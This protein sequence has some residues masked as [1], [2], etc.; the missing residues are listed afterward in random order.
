MTSPRCS[1]RSTTSAGAPGAAPIE[2][3]GG[4]RS[5]R[6]ASTSTAGCAGRRERF[7]D[8]YRA[9]LREAGAPIA[10]DPALLRA[11]EIDKEVYEYVYAAT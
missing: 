11:F 2:R 8:A 4:H 5:R 1:A 10:V 6:R 3:N 9:G 7:I